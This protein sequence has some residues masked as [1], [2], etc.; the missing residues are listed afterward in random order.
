[1]TENNQQEPQ[2][3][4]AQQDNSTVTTDDFAAVDFEAPIRR[5]HQ[6]GLQESGVPVPKY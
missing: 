2:D 5:Q 1:M 3:G 4:E 6:G